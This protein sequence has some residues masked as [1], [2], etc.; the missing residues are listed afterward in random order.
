[1][2]SR[3]GRETIGFE[4]TLHPPRASHEA[5]ETVDTLIRFCGGSS[6][7]RFSISEANKINLR[8]GEGK[9]IRD[10]GIMRAGVRKSLRSKVDSRRMVVE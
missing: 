8:T 7:V 5:A 1:V 9:G 3:T 4:W 10:T 2:G 6:V